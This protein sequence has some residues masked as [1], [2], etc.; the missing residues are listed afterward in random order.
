[1]SASIAQ[2]W[3]WAINRIISNRVNQYKGEQCFRSPFDCFFRGNLLGKWNTF[4]VSI[5]WWWWWWLSWLDCWCRETCTRQKGKDILDEEERKQ[6]TVTHTHTQFER[7]S[8]WRDYRPPTIRLG[9]GRGSL[10]ARTVSTEVCCQTRVTQ[11]R[12]SVER[13]CVCVWKFP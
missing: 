4:E 11:H 3:L 9:Q 8:K 6:F 10:R 12:A 13:V 7:N 5:S 1:M 2:S